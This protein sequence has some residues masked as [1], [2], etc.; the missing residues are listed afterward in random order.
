MFSA[1]PKS[2]GIR[3]VMLFGVV[4][5]FI[6]QPLRYTEVKMVNNLQPGFSKSIYEVLSATLK[7]YGI[8]G[9]YSGY[10]INILRN[11]VVLLPYYLK[12]L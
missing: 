9:I 8:S 7:R 3:E 12:M 10:G 5:A 6:E 4:Q 11:Q 2:L 1:T